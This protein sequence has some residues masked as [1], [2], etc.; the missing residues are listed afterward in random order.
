MAE[1]KDTARELL[2]SKLDYLNMNKSILDIDNKRDTVLKK[3]IAKEDKLNLSAK[4]LKSINKDIKSFSEDRYDN[5][6][7]V[8]ALFKIEKKLQ[9]EILSGLRKEVSYEELITE[10]KLESGKISGVISGTHSRYLEM[11]LQT[12]NELLK[13]KSINDKLE[14]IELNREASA[15]ATKNI[16]AVLLNIIKEI[17]RAS[18]SLRTNL[19]LSVNYSKDLDK[20]MKKTYST[21]LL[22]GIE[23]EKIVET[24]IALEST[25]G[26]TEKINKKLLTD[27]SIF[28][29]ALGISASTS[30]SILDLFQNISESSKESAINLLA[31]AKRTAEIN[32]VAPA[33]VMQDIAENTNFFAKYSKEAGQNIINAAIYARQ[34][35]LS[36]STVAKTT[37]HLL[38]FES[39]IASE[40]QASVILG[41]DISF[42]KARELSFSGKHLEAMKEITNQLGKQVEWDKLNFIQKDAIAQAVG[43]TE[44][45][46]AKLINRQKTLLKLN[47]K[48]ISINKALS[49]GLSMKD[50]ISAKDT[51]DSFSRLTMSLKAFGVVAATAIIPLLSGLAKLLDMLTGLIKVLNILKIPIGILTASFIL[52]EGSLIRTTMSTIALTTATYAKIAANIKDNIV[53]LQLIGLYALEKAQL[54][55]TTVAMYAKS[56][57]TLVLSSATTIATG[58]MTGFAVAVNAAIWPITLIVLAIGAL[59]GIGVLLYKKFPGIGESLKNAF[60][61][62]W[63]FIKDIPEKIKGLF[64]K[65]YDFFKD[66]WKTILIGAILGPIGWIGGALYIKFKDVINNAIT[67]AMTGIIETLKGLFLK[68][69]DFFKDNWKTILIGPIGWIGGALYIKFKDVINGAITKAMT[70]IIE[71]LKGF[72]KNIFLALIDP[73]V[74]AFDFLFLHTV[75]DSKAIIGVFTPILETIIKIFDRIYLAIITPFKLAFEFIE[76]LA[77]GQN[78]SPSVNVSTTTT[79]TQQTDATDNTAQKT[80]S[81]TSTQQTNSTNI[82]KLIARMDKLAELMELTLAQ[83]RAGS[84]KSRIAESIDTI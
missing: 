79:S 81:A 82:E 2:Q 29:K 10:Y 33:L 3:I 83:N 73:F 17:D 24:T 42:N 31:A 67:K 45:E 64:L 8:N 68:L 77:F 70:G 65:L 53:T 75:W 22:Y 35:G 84:L 61:S 78:I 43:L 44:S 80:T 20:A 14:E 15:K 52:L 16:N 76:K 59:I 27:I 55:G 23:M 4:L 41:K 28:S 47:T 37:E 39:S 74:H 21:T 49:E 72:G 69:Y 18:A 11:L 58:V 9:K 36:L 57:A 34:L 30:V 13:Q 63:E 12:S 66:N 51:Q 38:D 40:L 19:G 46:T 1:K 62:A 50:V 56:A 60:M 54:I 7:Q 71:T 32:D 25:L 6:K 48:Q 26:A 5:T